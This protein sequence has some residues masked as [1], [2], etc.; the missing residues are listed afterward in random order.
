MALAVALPGCDQEMRAGVESGIGQAQRL[1]AAE[2]ARL[3]AVQRGEVLREDRPFYGAAVQADRG[4]VSGQPLPA[5]VEGARGVRLELG[6]QADVAAVAAAITA[7][8]GIPVNIRT[9]YVSADG[10]VEVPIGTRMAASH[11]GPLSA[12]LDRMSARMDVAWSHDGRVITIDRMARRT[13]QVAL[14]LGATGITDTAPDGGSGTSV[15]TTRQ[16]DAWAELEAR[17]APVTPPPA[18]VTLSPQSG[19]VEVFGPPS[20][21]AAAGQVIGDAAATAAMRIA[22]EIAVYWVDSSRADDFGIGLDASALAGDVSVTAAIPLELAA[23]ARGEATAGLVIARGGSVLNFEALSRD[24]AVVD[25]R[26]ASTV[27]QSGAVAPIAIT[28]ERSY[29]RS[30]SDEEDEDGNVRRSYEI[31][32]LSTG[33]SVTAL[34]RLIGPRQV[35]LALTVSRRHLIGFDSPGDGST[36]VQLPR[37]DSRSLRNETLLRVGETL[38]LSGYEQDVAAA[39]RKGVGILRRFGIGGGTGVRQGKIRMVLLVRPSVI[40]AGGAT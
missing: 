24:G 19:R 5:A 34:P 39:E 12:F 18:R 26:L 17:L 16:L 13:W 31:G 6:G 8:S 14:P 15:S 23:A 40:P 35:Q 25:Y 21:L 20:V 9:R 36:A 33:L 4:S 29:V 10:V 28:E 7:A 37:I 30:V 2:R 22:L 11:E 1:T 27:A 32:E 3:R 38:V